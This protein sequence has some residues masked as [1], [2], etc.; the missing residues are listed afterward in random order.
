MSL[1]QV[2]SL[3]PPKTPPPKA[4]FKPTITPK[5]NSHK[6]Q[7]GDSLSSI[8]VKY[9]VSMQAIRDLNKLKDDNVKLDTTLKIPQSWLNVLTY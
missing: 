2:Q 8:A 5:N 9:G 6:V 3:L 7:K 1:W 4:E